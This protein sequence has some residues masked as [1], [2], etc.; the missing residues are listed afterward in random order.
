MRKRAHSDVQGAGRR[1]GG[2]SSAK[3]CSSA[4]WG[5]AGYAKRGGVITTAR[6]REVSTGWGGAAAGNARLPRLWDGA[7]PR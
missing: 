6:G 5:M 2:K 1:C 7:A 3:E 4:N